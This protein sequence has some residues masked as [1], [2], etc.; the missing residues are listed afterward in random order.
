MVAFAKRMPED[1]AVVASSHGE[2]YVDMRV[3][4]EIEAEG[5]AR[6][7]VRRIQQM[8][9][10]I[11]LDVEDYIQTVVK[12]RREFA[13]ILEAWKE[14]I[15]AETRSRSL[16]LGGDPSKDEYIVQWTVEGET[17]EIGITPLH[18]SGAIRD[19]TKALELDPAI[20]NALLFRGLT[21]FET[22]DWKGAVSDLSAAGEQDPQSQDYPRLL[23]WIARVRLGEREAAEPELRKYVRERPVEDWWRSLANH[24]LGE[25][26]EEELLLAAGNSRDRLCEARFYAGCR[27]SIEGDREAARSHFKACRETQ[28]R[29]MSEYWSAAAELEAIDK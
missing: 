9:K 21:R 13:Q 7:V 4:P 20:E 14:Y 23:I 28:A 22:R 25:L 3:T 19:F 10:E 18:M 12:V 29:G 27:C 2:I 6:E 15:A 24:L 11:D 16:T 26:K 1:I 8:R 17:F 5:Y